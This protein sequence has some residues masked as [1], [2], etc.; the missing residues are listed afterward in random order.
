MKKYCPFGIRI[1]A[2]VRS[3]RRSGWMY[4]SFSRLPLM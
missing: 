4:G 2:I 1:G 3:S